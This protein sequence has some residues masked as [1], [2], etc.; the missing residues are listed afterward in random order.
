M[1]APAGL[2]WNSTV[3]VSAS[4]LALSVIVPWTAAPGSSR[5]GDGALLSTRTVCVA[6]VVAW[7]AGSVARTAIVMFP[8]PTPCVSYDAIGVEPLETTEPLTR[9]S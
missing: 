1:F 2:R 4:E 3:A 6:D 8:S 9:K 7:P 5:L